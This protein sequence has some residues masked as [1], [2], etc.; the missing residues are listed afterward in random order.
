MFIHESIGHFSRNLIGGNYAV[1]FD[2]AFDI[3]DVY[4]ACSP[5]FSTCRMNFRHMPHIQGYFYRWLVLT[6]LVKRH[7]TRV[8]PTRREREKIRS[9]R[10]RF[11]LWFVCL[12]R[13]RWIYK[14][15][16]EEGEE[17]RKRFN[18]FIDIKFLYYLV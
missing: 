3:R 5:H 14:R 6:R 18:N 1:K 7:G 9:L 13:S 2:D 10:F 12:V 16:K 11:L 8:G 4:P 17:K 15:D